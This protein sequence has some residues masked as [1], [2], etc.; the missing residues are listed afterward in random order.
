MNSD[1]YLELKGISKAFPGVRALDGVTMRLRP[2]TMHA[3]VGENGAG[4]STLMKILMGMIT[5]YDGDIFLH[6]RKL[7]HKGV[8]QSLD[9]G[10]A[11]IH[12]ELTYVPHMTVAEN[13]FLGKEPIFKP[14]FWVDRK[15]LAQKAKSLLQDLS[16]DLD[17]SCLMKDLSVAQ[18]Q[19]VE[20]AKALSYQAQILIMDEPTSALSQ[21]E[22]E[23]LFA[24][25]TELK[26]QG[27]TIIYI[28][29]KLEEVFE[30]A[31]EVTVLRDGRVIDSLDIQKVDRDALIA[32][33]VGRE[34]AEVFPPRCGEV[35]S[36]LLR[37]EGLTRQGIFQE[38]SFSLHRGEILGLA[39]LMGA[40]RTEVIRCLFGL[41]RLDAGRVYLHQQQ[42]DLSHPK[43][44]LR[45]GVGLVSEDRRVWGLV[46]CLSIRENVTLAHLSR[47]SRR[48]V[49][50]A[51][52]ENRLADGMVRDLNIK[53][54]SR[55]SS[56]ST[57]SGGNQQK[58]VFGKTLMGEP[59]ILILDEP[60][61]G[62]D[63]GAKA[64]IYQLIR[65]L[66]DRGKAI[67]L[68][69]S[70]LTEILGMSDRI[71]VMHEGRVTGCLD[72][73]EATPETIMKLAI[74]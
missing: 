51:G 34:L 54:S 41:D 21:R 18:Q 19:M 35:G 37:V 36:E 28:S 17:P 58:V 20:I 24:V 62:I 11:M 4:K 48:S 29:H 64:E 9:L 6:G 50:Q 33:M 1:C 32:M 52:Q 66:A 40:G 31:D 13:I 46:P 27:K 44:A 59:E 30:L 72:G 55:D 2:G 74:A 61:R 14:F 7:Q 70:E 53:T 73:A 39:G 60:T 3:L 71:L 56:V 10:I 15:T 22:V 26:S 25:M 47:C 12:Q 69:S 8:R 38:V 43:D 63:V 65:S 68:I 57:L 16:L 23:R 67:L 45:Q 49:I 42:I 5:D